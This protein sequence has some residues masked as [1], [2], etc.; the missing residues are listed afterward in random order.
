MR[1][2]RDGIERSFLRVVDPE[3]IAEQCCERPAGLH[4]AFTPTRLRRHLLPVGLGLKLGD[5]IAGGVGIGLPVNRLQDFGEVGQ[6]LGQVGTVAVRA[7]GDQFPVYG[8]RFFDDCQGRRPGGPARR[9]GRRGW[10]ATGRGRDGS[11]PGWRRPAPG[12]WRPLPR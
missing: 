11:G 6:R 7:G 8:D 4:A 1:G 2:R 5:F 9:T 12:I 10:S 3:L